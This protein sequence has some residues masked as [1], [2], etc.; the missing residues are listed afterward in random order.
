MPLSDSPDLVG[1]MI[2]PSVFVLE[3]GSVVVALHRG[4]YLPAD[5]NA[6]A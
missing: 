6:D 4:R 2:T 3:A 1:S 5:V